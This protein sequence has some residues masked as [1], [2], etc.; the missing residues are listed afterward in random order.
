MKEQEEE[1]VRIIHSYRVSKNSETII[2]GIPKDIREQYDLSKPTSLY[3]LSQLSR[4]DFSFTY[5][6]S[7][8]HSSYTLSNKLFGFWLSCLCFP[9]CETTRLN[10]CTTW[11]Q[12]KQVH[13]VTLHQPLFINLSTFMIMPIDSSFFSKTSSIPLLRQDF[14]RINLREAS[15]D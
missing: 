15:I 10:F 2:F 1:G 14:L 11:P 6:F 3:L 13:L 4:Y 5:L 12:I 9:T 7:S 8:L